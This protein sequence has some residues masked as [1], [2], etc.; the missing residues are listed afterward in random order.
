LLT[1]NTLTASD[2]IL[3]PIQCEYYALEGVS[4]LLNTIE[5]VKRSLNPSLA[6]EG[7]VMTMYDGRT[8]LSNQVCEEIKKHFKEKVYN[9]LVPR[10]VRLSEAPSYGKPVIL[11]DIKS[12]GSEAYLNLAKEVMQNAERIG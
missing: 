8:T 9:T 7:V 4:K 2:S 5:L 11:Y 10:N 6:I 3:I 12:S 1:L